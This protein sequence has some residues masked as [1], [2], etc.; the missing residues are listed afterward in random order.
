MGNC[1]LIPSPENRI[2]LRFLSEIENDGTRRSYLLSGT[3]D[4]RIKKTVNGLLLF[5]SLHSWKL[6]D[7]FDHS[8]RIEP[9]NAAER[10]KGLVLQRFTSSENI[11]IKKVVN[12]VIIVIERLGLFLVRTSS[13]E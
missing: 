11:N 13:G 5:L 7:T 12:E 1:I 2:I 3:T 10:I 6:S 9:I 4:E 8:V